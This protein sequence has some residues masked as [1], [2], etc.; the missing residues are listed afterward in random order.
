MYKLEIYVILKKDVFDPQG[1]AIL[2]AAKSIR[3]KNIA[4][5]KQGKYFEV[6]LNNINSLSEAK[7]IAQLLANRLLCNEVIETYKVINI[8]KT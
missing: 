2:E 8:K 1:K 6:T 5:I 7:N 4:D 3:I